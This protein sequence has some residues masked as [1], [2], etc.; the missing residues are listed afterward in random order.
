MLPTAAAIPHTPSC[1]TLPHSA[2]CCLPGR[3]RYSLRWIS[4]AHLLQDKVRYGY[5]KTNVI[6]LAAK[7]NAAKNVWVFLT[8]QTDW[9]PNELRAKR[10]LFEPPKI[11]EKDTIGPKGV[12]LPARWDW[13]DLDKVSSGVGRGP[14]QLRL[15]CI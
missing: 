5:F 4:T 10:K 1:R 11:K 8:F 2:C 12:A 7:L 6:K 14:R 15:C 3:R 13:Q 9:S